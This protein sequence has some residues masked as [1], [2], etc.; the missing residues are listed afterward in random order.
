[1]I[2][3]VSPQEFL[4]SQNYPNPFNPETN[5]DFNLSEEGET[6]L[7]IFDILGN[8]ISEY[9]NTALPAGKH[10][11]KID[12]SKLSAGNYIYQLETFGSDPQAVKIQTKKMTLLK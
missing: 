10:S 11:I 3:I 6:K 5:V 2:D 8:K 1:M 4:L 7:I 9:I 12:G